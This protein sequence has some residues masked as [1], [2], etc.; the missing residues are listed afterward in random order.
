M[1]EASSEDRPSLSSDRPSFTSA[2]STVARGHVLFELG[3]QLDL[4]SSGKMLQLPQALA[5]WGLGQGFELRLTIPSI[6]STWPKDSVYTTDMTPME[7]GT[8]IIWNLGDRVALGLLP[9][10]SIPLKSSQYDS[11]GAALGFRFIWGVSIL[12]WLSINGDLGMTFSGLGAQDTDQEY[13]A[14]LML[15]FALNGWMG[16]FIEAYTDF[17][18]GQDKVP[19]FANA[20]L[21]FALGPSWQ[22]DMVI[23]TDLSDG[24]SSWSIGAGGALLW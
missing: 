13:Q 23:G 14:S 1:A 11:T 2:S 3:T 18:D 7:I 22:L 16:G 17:I 10:A 8:K 15:T 20:G 4:D 24:L 12:D 9:F 6:C 19:V 5:R 21:A